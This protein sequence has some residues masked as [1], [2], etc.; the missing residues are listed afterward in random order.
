MWENHSRQK[1]LK[2]LKYS[3]DF[4]RQASELSRRILNNSFSVEIKNNNTSLSVVFHPVRSQSTA[5]AQEK[6]QDHLQMLQEDC[7]FLK[8]C[9]QFCFRL[10]STVTWFAVSSWNSNAHYDAWLHLVAYFHSF[11]RRCHWLFLFIGP[12]SFW[13]LLLILKEEKTQW[14][15]ETGSD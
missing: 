8:I 10:S 7:T 2:R 12:R 5:T 9:P 6:S 4:Q 14:C 3:R 11:P 15:T 1:K 13:H